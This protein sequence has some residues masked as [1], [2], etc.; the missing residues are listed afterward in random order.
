MT[1]GFPLLPAII[2]SVLLAVGLVICIG[3]RVQDILVLLPS[4]ENNRRPSLKR[5]ISEAKG[6]VKPFFIFRVFQEAREILKDTYRE[7]DYENYKRLS[8]RMMI[9]GAIIGLCF[10]NPFLSIAL[11]LFGLFLPIFMI[12]LTAASF[13]TQFAGEMYTCM[14][15]ISTGCQRKFDLVNAAEENVGTMN[16][17]M[18]SH[19]EA[20]LRDFKNFDNNVSNGIRKL[21]KK[22]ND[23]VWQEWC[24]DLLLCQTDPTRKFLLSGAVK[25]AIQQSRVR[26]MLD[27]ILDEPIFQA[28]GVMLIA[29]ASIPIC[30][31]FYPDWG[32]LLMH[33]WQGKLSIAIIV[34]ACLYL[35]FKAVHAS[36]PIDLLEEVE[37]GD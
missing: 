9:A 15:V 20:F 13:R 34:L 14:S 26:M 11:A 17:P 8:V 10:L 16:E 18:K 6:Q 23:P 30:G 5:R 29:I 2:V 24:D 7:K 12:H 21:R 37:K 1:H 22:I 3:F 31:F 28:V 27:S 25:K 19:W 33:S 32:Y 36:R 35:A 4:G